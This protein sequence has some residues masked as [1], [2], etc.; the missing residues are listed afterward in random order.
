[1]GIQDGRL[2]L[3]GVKVLELTRVIVGSGVGRFLGT[4]GAEVVHVESEKRLDF[5]RTSFP[6]KDN[7]PGINR[8]GYF[9]RYNP[10][11]YG[12]SLD[13]SKREGLDIMKKLV[14]WA[15]VFIESNVPG[16]VD[17][18]G[19][20]Y[21]NVRKLNPGI[22]MLSTSQM[23]REGPL[24]H[25]KGFG[26][27]TA[28]MAGFHQITG[29]GD[30]PMG[31]FG[32]YTDMVS[33]QWLITA[34]LAALDHRRRTGQGQYID[35]SQFEAGVHAL[36]PAVL[37]CS[38]NGEIAPQVANRDALAAPHGCYRCMGEDRWCAIAVCSDEEWCAFCAVLGD[39]AW[40]REARF[41]SLDAR[42]QNE[43][44]LNALV[45]GWT[46]RNTAEDV[47]A[48]L[49]SAGIAAGVVSTGED[50][51]RNAQL[52]ARGY[53]K[54][55]QHSEIGPTPF[56]N[57]PFRFAKAPGEVRKPAPC[58][59]EHTELVCREILG[60]SDEEFVDLLQK[61]VFE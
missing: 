10:D 20:D 50:L 56:S 48:G 6:Y 49:Q 9:H 23:G 24:A 7:V 44:D 15:D 52:A 21:G 60:M 2:P 25:Y 53:F 30:G 38:S 47:M 26:V 39:P 55:L 32:A 27:Q 18:F 31:P 11:K 29:Y 43:D 46:R 42:K 59:G 35:H 5:L 34:L 8:A 1:M 54:V 33:I 22:V 40:T 14:A 58:F 61:R 37:G 13:L 57:P 3:K 45:E 16:M 4:A 19:L 36:A 12:I 41:A 17:K 51:N 28:A